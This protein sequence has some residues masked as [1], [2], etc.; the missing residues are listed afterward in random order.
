[1]KKILGL[2][3]GLM[4]GSFVFGQ[5][6]VS[7]SENLSS[8]DKTVAS[9]FHFNVD[10]SITGTEIT[11]NAQYYT[12]YFTVSKTAASGGHDITITMANTDAISKKVIMRYFTQLQV[13]TINVEG[14]EVQLEDFMTTYIYE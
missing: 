14:N 10:Q 9:E 1:M 13:G 11:D 6:A 4:I 2:A 8:Y 5:S 7:F 3:F 12:D